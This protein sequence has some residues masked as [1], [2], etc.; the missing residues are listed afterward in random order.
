MRYSY[1][2]RIPSCT[3]NMQLSLE[4]KKG[5]KRRKIDINAFEA[6]ERKYRNQ[7]SLSITPLYFD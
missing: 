7:S 2:L 1:A 5:D 3:L 6:G 4:E